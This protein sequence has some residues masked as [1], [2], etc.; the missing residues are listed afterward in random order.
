MSW[1]RLVIVIVFL[2]SCGTSDLLVSEIID[3]NTVRLSDGSIVEL[4][5]VTKSMDNKLWLQEKLTGTAVMVFDSKMQPIKPDISH[6]QGYLYNEEGLNVNETLRS[7]K[8]NTAATS[9]SKKNWSEQ[10]LTQLYQQ[11]QPAVF[12]IFTSDEKSIHQGTGF[13]IDPVGIAV[14]NY[15]VFEGTSQGLEVIKVNDG[16]EYRIERVLVMN[17][18]HDYIV[19]KVAGIS[20]PVPYIKTSPVIPQVGSN[21]FT[22]GNPK[23]LESTLSTGIIS[24]LRQGGT[25]IQTTTEIT[26]GSSG[27]PLLNMR[28]EVIGITTSGVGEANLNFAININFIDWDNIFDRK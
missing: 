18:E 21:V 23:G 11:L 16:N 10:S 14:S 26:N 5:D 17:K 15:H 22:I 8:K 7:K 3:G 25:I 20:N 27:G 1:F 19:F 2:C 24:S 4:V 9:E 13:F 28:G 12:V 6:V